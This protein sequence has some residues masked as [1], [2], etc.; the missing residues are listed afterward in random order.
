MKTDRI[1]AGCLIGASLLAAIAVFSKP[2]AT[3]WFIDDQENA[4][5][6]MFEINGTISDGNLGEPFSTTAQS[7]QIIRQIRQAEKDGAKAFIIKIN[8]PGGTAAAS[9]AIYQELMRIRAK[10]IPIVA[11]FGDVAASGGYYIGAAA[12]H[13]VASPASTTGSIGVIVHTTDISGLMAKL[14]VR[15]T[16]IKSGTYKD[17]LSP[18]RS[19]TARERQLLQGLVNDT[20]SQFVQAVSTGRNLPINKVRTLADGRIFTGAE[21]KRVGLVDSLG[22]YTDAIDL[23]GKMAK[24]EGEPT[25]HNYSSVSFWDRVIPRMEALLPSSQINWNKIPLALME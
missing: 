20:F 22:N 15:A 4:E 17:I 6:A 24:I 5:I 23:A 9:Q 8:S 7:S 2:K 10:K 19:M 25:I 18:Y 12:N 14:G 13:I 11:S 21:A 16:S 1:I 3:P